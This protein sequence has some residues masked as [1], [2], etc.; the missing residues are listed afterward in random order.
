MRLQ[1]VWMASD[2]LVKRRVPD[3][4][5]CSITLI[6]SPVSMA[7]ELATARTMRLRET[8]TLAELFLRIINRI[9]E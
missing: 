3:L 7:L 8:A 5:R 2:S 1:D 6:D 9:P 4:R